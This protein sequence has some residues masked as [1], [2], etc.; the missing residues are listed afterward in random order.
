MKFWEQHG[1]NKEHII[2]VDNEGSEFETTTTKHCKEG[3]KTMGGRKRTD[4]I[5]QRQRT[6]CQLNS[7]VSQYKN[8]QNG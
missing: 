3:S 1:K 4:K 8:E 6:I 2:D 7:F 5:Y